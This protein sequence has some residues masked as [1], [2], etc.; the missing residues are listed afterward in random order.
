MANCI[1]DF[2]I[3]I[4]RLNLVKRKNGVFQQTE[5]IILDYLIQFIQLRL[6]ISTKII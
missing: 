2:T 1:K 5:L 4:I 6:V 3:V